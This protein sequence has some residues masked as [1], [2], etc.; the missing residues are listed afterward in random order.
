METYT[1]LQ[2]NYPKSG[3]RMAEAERANAGRYCPREDHAS[4]LDLAYISFGEER[5]LARKPTLEGCSAK[6]PGGLSFPNSPQMHKVEEANARRTLEHRMH[7]YKQEQ[8][9]QRE[10][11]RKVLRSYGEEV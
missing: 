10:V 8:G 4:C 2:L 3:C 1:P 5:A 9:Q 11:L 7:F 6:P